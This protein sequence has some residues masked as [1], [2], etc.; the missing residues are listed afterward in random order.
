MCPKA[1][2][3]REKAGRFAARLALPALSR[4]L[5]VSPIDTYPPSFA[6][7]NSDWRRCGWPVGLPEAVTTLSWQAP[8]SPMIE[9][10]HKPDSPQPALGLSQSPASGIWD[11]MNPTVAVCA[12]PVAEDN[13]SLAHNKNRGWAQRPRQRLLRPTS[14]AFK[15]KDAAFRR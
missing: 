10:R 4:T 9:T 13:P 15:K 3:C 2:L 11:G 7:R 1:Q 12:P 6:F 8:Q 14:F 5:Q